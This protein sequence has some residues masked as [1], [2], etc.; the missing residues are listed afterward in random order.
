VCEITF[1]NVTI[2][3]ISKSN[4]SGLVVPNLQKRRQLRE[5]GRAIVRYLE[6]QLNRPKDRDGDKIE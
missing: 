4:A 1:V 2:L 3:E 5:Q 6:V